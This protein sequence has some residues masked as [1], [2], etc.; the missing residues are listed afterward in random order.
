MGHRGDTSQGSPQILHTRRDVSTWQL[1]MPVLVAAG[2]E[3]SP[4]PPAKA[5][6]GRWG[7]GGGDPDV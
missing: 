3:A 6:A 7:D 5:A 4:L 1:C 2:C